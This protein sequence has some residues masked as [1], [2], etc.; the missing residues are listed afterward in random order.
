MIYRLVARDTVEERV[1]KLQEKKQS[2]ADAAVGEGSVDA[3][4]NREELLDLLR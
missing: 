2:L 4:V 3:S 1:L